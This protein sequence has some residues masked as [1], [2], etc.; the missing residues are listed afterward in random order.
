MGKTFEA[1]HDFRLVVGWQQGQRGTRFR[2]Q[3]G[4]A[5]DAE[6]FFVGGGYNADGVEENPPRSPFFKGGSRLN[7]PLDKLSLRNQVS[8]VMA[9]KKV[10][11][12]LVGAGVMSAT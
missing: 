6:F 11:V 2:D 9:Q 5:R 12:L 10:D 7:F 3:A 8:Q 1:A 4:L